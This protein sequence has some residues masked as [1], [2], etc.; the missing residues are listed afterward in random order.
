MSLLGIYIDLIPKILPAEDALILF[1]Y[2]QNLAETGVISYNPGKEPAEGATDFLWMVLLAIGTWLGATPFEVSIALNWVGTL[3]GMLVM[4]QIS[5]GN[6][7]LLA[8]LW[9]TWLL[10]TQIWAALQGF[11][12]MFWG[13]LLW[14]C[15]WTYWENKYK[16]LIVISFLTVLTRPDGLIVVAPLILV[17]AWQNR[18][19]WREFVVYLLLGAIIPGC[20]Y[21]IWRYNYFGELLPLP[22]YV[23]TSYEKVLGI[24]ELKS[25]KYI[26]QYLT[27]YVSPLII[28]IL[29]IFRII[30]PRKRL[31]YVGI[32]IGFI[33][34]P[35]LF[36]PAITLDQNIANRYVMAIPVGGMFLMGVNWRLHR[37]VPQLAMLF[38]ILNAIYAPI[39]LARTLKN[40]QA[41]L[42]RQQLAVALNQI[43]S[44]KLATTE[45]GR[46]PYYSE[47]E[48][49]DIW[50]LNTPATAHR[51]VISRDL[52][53]FDPDLI[54]L[55]A[56]EIGFE[57]LYTGINLPYRKTRTWDNVNFNVLKFVHESEN[58]KIF[59]F[60]SEKLISQPY[61]KWDIIV[62]RISNFYKWYAKLMGYQLGSS[63]KST[64]YLIKHD[65]PYY[66]Q[67]Q[68]IFIK[69]G[70]IPALLADKPQSDKGQ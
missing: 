6:L 65:S 35:S 49:F 28:G 40:S 11:S 1:R 4:Y 13:G 38:L 45:A 67:V 31:R 48:T 14:I 20:A 21:F 19:Q 41:S 17:S 39:Y 57:A 8:W 32:I 54:L 50:G 47:W 46:L 29:I 37:W 61:D 66:N 26:A 18:D 43:K 5:R 64:L 7:P 69:H 2:S 27:R 16:W 60:E 10:F 53:S 33:V 3:V 44:Q 62:E 68:A 51:I 56:G 9:I 23:K 52:I 15:A 42:N 22:F 25:I 58:Y 55:N 24:F 59:Y 34:L 63:G 70:A 30:Q 12:V 36:Y